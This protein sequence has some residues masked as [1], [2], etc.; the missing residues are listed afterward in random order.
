MSKNNKSGL[1]RAIKNMVEKKKFVPTGD[2][3]K[4]PIFIQ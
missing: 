4:A 1:G 2:R 3:D